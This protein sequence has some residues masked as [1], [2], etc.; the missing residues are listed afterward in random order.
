M[1]AQIEAFKELLL[2]REGHAEANEAECVKH[3]C[4][5]CQKY[6]KVEFVRSRF[7]YTWCDKCFD[8]I[9]PGQI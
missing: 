6:F 4:E 8:I 7:G 5:M 2:E 1:S 9:F 3:Q